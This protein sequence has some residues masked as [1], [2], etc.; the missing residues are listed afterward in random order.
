MMTLAYLAIETK[1]HSI[2]EVWARLI[3]DDSKWI[4]DLTLTALCFSCCVYCSSFI[5]DI[6]ISLSSATNLSGLFS[7]RASMLI[8]VTIGLLAPLCFLGNLSDLQGSSVLGVLGVLSTVLIHIRRLID[9]SYVPGHQIYD[10][11]PEMK[12]PSWDVETSSHYFGGKLNLFGINKGTLI[13]LNA[14]CV[15]F[16]GHHNALEYYKKLR[17][18]SPQ[19]YKNTILTAYG[20]VF[21]IST[22]MMIIGYC[23][24]GR[25]VQP[26]ILNNFHGFKDKLATSAR[27]LTGTAISLAYPVVFSG[28]RSSLFELINLN[29]HPKYLR[30]IVSVVVLTVITFIACKYSDNNVGV[31]LGI[32]G[33][34]LGCVTAYI[35]PAILRLAYMNKQKRQGLFPRQNQLEVLLNHFLL[36][37]G[38]MF[39]ILGLFMTLEEIKKGGSRT[40][41]EMLLQQGVT[42]MESTSS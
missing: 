4:V 8:I 41:S 36:S 12:R 3:G 23:I 13:L 14:I 20:A 31:I 17:N 30:D 10:N 7:N 22:I 35:L 16:L 1:A 9:K 28:L 27:I 19:R 2:G 11:L 34:F 40:L 24:F 18:A 5:G 38:I 25:T 26:N 29:S 33:S 21:S 32:M 42:T 15:A 6:S 39:S 37:F